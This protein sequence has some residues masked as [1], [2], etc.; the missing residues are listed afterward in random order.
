MAVSSEIDE[1]RVKNIYDSL[2]QSTAITTEQ[3]I[4]LFGSIDTNKRGTVNIEALKF[5][6]YNYG[7]KL[8]NNETDHL[9]QLLGA[10]E[11]TKELQIQ[12]IVQIIDQIQKSEG[13]FRF[14]I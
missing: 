4:K 7:E 8:E 5:L 12:S 14:S 11:E 6:L 2:K 13:F 9:C 3:L 10:K 1:R